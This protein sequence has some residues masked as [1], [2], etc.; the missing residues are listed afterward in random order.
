MA[1]IGKIIDKALDIAD[2]VNEYLPMAP[3]SQALID[4]ARGV[5]DLLES[6]GE[7]IP[8]DK[9]TE[10]QAARR[11]IAQRVT[12]KSRELSANLRG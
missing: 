3:A 8:L 6:F 4:L 1:D 11:V 12:A 9:Q 10:A 7:D 5:D 2:K